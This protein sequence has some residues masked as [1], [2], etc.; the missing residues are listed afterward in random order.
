MP[1]VVEGRRIHI[2]GTVQGVGFQP[3][4]LHAPTG[5]SGTHSFPAKDS[6][7]ATRSQP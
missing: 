5:A 2:A 3:W 7:T 1:A 4:I 6:R